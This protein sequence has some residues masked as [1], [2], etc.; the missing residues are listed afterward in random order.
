MS[1]LDG[2]KGYIQSD[3]TLMALTV[4]YYAVDG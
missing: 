2:I 1:V 4:T 3:R